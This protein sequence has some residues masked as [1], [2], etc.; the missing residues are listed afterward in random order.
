[1]HGLL[2][3][4]RFDNQDSANPLCFGAIVGSEDAHTQTRTER[5]TPLSTPSENILSHT[6][7]C[8]LHQGNPKQ[9]KFPLPKEVAE[10]FWTAIRPARRP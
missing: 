9:K 8:Q 4:C 5:E 6:H 1:M 2:G 3:D 10:V 7:T